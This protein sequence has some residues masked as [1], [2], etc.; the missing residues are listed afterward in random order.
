MVHLWQH[1]FGKP[2]R[3]GYHTGDWAVKMRAIGL[4]PTSTGEPGGKETGQKV[5][6][7]IEPGGRFERA[8]A[9]FLAS[10]VLYHDR[11]GEGREPARKKKAA[12]KT[13]YTCSGCGV[14]LLCGECQEPMHVEPDEQAPEALE[15]A[16]GA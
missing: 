12:S 11:A 7:F 14:S 4:I 16:I 10:I 5:T 3:S 1:H 13:K 8:C 15:E 2:S 9:A 6:H